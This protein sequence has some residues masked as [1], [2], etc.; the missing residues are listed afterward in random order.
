ME[1]G[2]EYDLA[3]LAFREW[4][5]KLNNLYVPLTEKQPNFLQRLVAALRSSR[6]GRAE[7]R[8]VMARGQNAQ[9][10]AVAK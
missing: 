6:E 7:N 2:N 1:Y 8:R 3:R 5:D 9:T 4:N 10:G